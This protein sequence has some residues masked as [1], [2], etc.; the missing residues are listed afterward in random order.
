[1]SG[2]IMFVQHLHFFYSSLLPH[3]IKVA[4]LILCLDSAVD[5][6]RT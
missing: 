3:G 6:Q 1:M 4:P 5:L 2:Q